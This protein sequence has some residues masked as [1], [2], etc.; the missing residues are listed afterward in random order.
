VIV[1]GTGIGGGT[2]GYALAKA[3]KRVLFCEKGKDHS[4][5]D[6]A[7]RGDYAE[8]FFRRPEVPQ[9][10][11]REILTRAGRWFAG[12][13]DASTEHSQHFIPF[14]GS[15]TGGSSA[16]YGGAM[17]R[18]F[19]EDFT[20]RRYYSDVAETTL[21]DRWPILYQE[22]EPYYEEAEQLFRV[23]GTVDPLRRHK[24]WKYLPPS[25]L[26]SVSREFYDFLQQKGLHPY[27]LPIA[28]DYVSGCMGCQGFLCDRECKNDSTQVCLEP[29][30]SRLGAQLLDECEVLRLKADRSRVTGVVC[31]K[32]GQEYDLRA[33]VFVLAAGA[34]GTPAILLK[35]NCS[36]WPNG[37]ANDSGLVGRNLMRHHIDL[38]AIFPKI[39]EG[40]P[41]NNKEIAFNDLYVL[42]GKKF[43]TIQSFGAMPPA[44]ILVEEIQEDLRYSPWP[45]L[46]SFFRLAKPMAKRILKHLFARTIILA[47]MKEDLP[48]WENRVMLSEPDSRGQR[49][50]ILK[51]RIRD[52]DRARIKEFRER[53]RDVFEPY[54]FLLIKQAENNKRLAHI[55][56]TCCFGR[57]PNESVLDAN[58]KAHGLKNL[59]VVDSSFFPSSGGTNPSLTIAA[60]ALRVADHLLGK[61]R[62]AFL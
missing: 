22:L 56:G 46:A 11:H 27:R 34:I 30:I 29:A 33:K 36:V 24:K 4:T 19:E 8:S 47:A 18:F 55:C 3:G 61:A 7:L 60:N 37:L 50:I 54:R 21:P 6:K 45:A 17:E 43:G 38:Y 35:S 39:R 49:R 20:P 25:P 41:G 23:R 51:Y 28:C 9:L 58:N 44:S 1:V 62:K 57:D 26:S 12:I 10:K 2:L 42:E 5:D 13:E 15:G 32:Q 53:V 14:L 52:C 59:Y 16:L 40:F 48:Y 31:S